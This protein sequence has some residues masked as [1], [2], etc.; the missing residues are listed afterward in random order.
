MRQSNKIVRK[1]LTAE[2]G[3]KLSVSGVKIK[4][5]FCALEQGSS[6]GICVSLKFLL[7]GTCEWPV[8]IVCLNSSFKIENIK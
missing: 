8:F 7:K 4:K 1:C 3:R 6:S 5:E 2:V